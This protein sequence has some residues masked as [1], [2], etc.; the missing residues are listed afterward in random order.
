MLLV[1]GGEFGC[2][3]IAVVKSYTK[4]NTMILMET[5]VLS[6]LVFHNSGNT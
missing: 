5:K 6:S 4:D 3:E 2:L 1:D